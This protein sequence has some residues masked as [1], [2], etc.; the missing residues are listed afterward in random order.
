[1]DTLNYKQKEG[2]EL[3][4]KKYF[5]VD[6]DRFID[7]R[8]LCLGVYTCDIIKFDEYMHKYYG[9]NEAEHGSLNDFLKLKFGIGAVELIDKLIRNY[10]ISF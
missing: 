3:L 4:F 8:L 2:F 1:M 9:Y 7:K 5:N 10:K 6:L